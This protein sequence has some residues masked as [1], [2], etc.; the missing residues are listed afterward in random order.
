MAGGY[1][2]NEAVIAKG[3]TVY[4]EAEYDNTTNNPLNPNTPPV[5]VGWGEK[6]V[7]RCAYF[8]ILHTPY[9]AGDENLVLVRITAN[10]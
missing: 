1:Y 3:T 2:F 10:S 4:A 6:P 8:P 7:M 5:A 9:K